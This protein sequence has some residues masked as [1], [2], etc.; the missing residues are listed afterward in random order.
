[1]SCCSPFSGHPSPS[2]PARTDSDPS[3]GF[4]VCRQT[5]PSPCPIFGWALTSLT[6][7]GGRASARPQPIQRFNASLVVATVRPTLQLSTD[8]S[9]IIPVYNE[10]ENV[11]PLTREVIDAMK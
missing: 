8:I 1:M 2:Q 9:I 5:L 11:L 7:P 6:R 3:K 10:Q 4:V